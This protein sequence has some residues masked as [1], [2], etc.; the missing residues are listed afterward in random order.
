MNYVLDTCVLSELA[1]KVPDGRV[2]AWLRAQAEERL[3]L[4]VLTLG[5]LQKGVTKLTDSKR[6]RDLQSWLDEDLTQRFAGRI[7]D[8][9]AAVAGTW[10]RLQG[11]AEQ[12]GRRLPVIDGLIAATA[13]NFGAAVVTRNAADMETSGVDIV[14]P[15]SARAT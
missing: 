2:V 12:A 13:L 3:Y 11:Q 9:T 4:S 5:E 7:L 15:W 8:V 14:N 1:K 6:R 10:G